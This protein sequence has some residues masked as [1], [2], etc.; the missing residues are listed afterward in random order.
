[1]WYFFLFY[2]VMFVFFFMFS[3][4]RT[5]YGSFGDAGS[6]KRLVSYVFVV[7]ILVL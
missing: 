5:V 4:M 6:N 3:V 7:V 1:M 2:W